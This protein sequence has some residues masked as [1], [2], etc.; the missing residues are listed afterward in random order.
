MNRLIIKFSDGHV[1]KLFNEQFDLFWQG[2]HDYNNT[3]KSVK[4]TE[5]YCIWTP[6][7]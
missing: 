6:S 1:L 7:L 2:F 5:M 3:S 4:I